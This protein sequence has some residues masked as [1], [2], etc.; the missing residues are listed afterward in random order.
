MPALPILLALTLAAEAPPAA[1]AAPSPPPAA[2]AVA[3]AAPA[4]DAAG[5]VVAPLEAEPAEP[6]PAAP[7]FLLDGLLPP[8]RPAIGVGLRLGGSPAGLES[9][10]EPVVR[11]RGGLAG[12]TVGRSAGSGEGVRA[13]GL[14]VGYGL[15]RGLYRGEALLGWGRATV[16]L[17]G[18]GQP[19][20]PSGHFRSALLGVDRAVA[21]GE[22][23]RA[24]LGAALWWRGAFGLSRGA[25]DR[26]DL[27]AGIRL[28]VEAGL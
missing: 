13:L 20:S 2:V 18:G 8:A 14:L 7:P 5:V 4:E 22:G 16:G 17:H 6:A 3:P 12:V 9:A 19:G 24:S 26:D 15:T 21:G 23:W 25:A 1:E 27:G 11:W 28:G 10:V